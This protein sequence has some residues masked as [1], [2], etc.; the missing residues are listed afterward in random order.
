MSPPANHRVAEVLADPI[1]QLMMRADG[2]DCRTL[3]KELHG[4]ARRLREK[5]PADHD[6]QDQ[7]DPAPAGWLA[8]CCGIEHLKRIAS[9]GVLCR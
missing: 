5:R 7:D 6:A 3:A 2:V 8:A 4:V 9:T 1:V